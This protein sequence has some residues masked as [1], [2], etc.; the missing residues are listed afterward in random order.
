M[1]INSK[2]MN[3]FRANNGGGGAFDENMYPAADGEDQFGELNGDLGGG[4]DLIDE[5]ND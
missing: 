2:L 4:G 3:D 1:I 5:P